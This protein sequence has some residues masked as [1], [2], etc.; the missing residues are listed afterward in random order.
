[1]EFEVL[2]DLV[3]II[4]RN[5]VK[6]IEVLGNPGQDNSR[7]EELY[8]GIGK[9]RFTSDDEAAKF[10]FGTNEK[11]PNYRK[12]R[13]KLIR[14]LI[15]T[16]FFID[17]QQPMFSERSKAQYHCYRDYAA[18]FILRTREAHKASVYLLQQVLEQAIKYEFTELTADICQQLR[19]QFARTP[20][21]Q[22]SHEKYSTLHRLYEEKRY[23]EVK[24]LDYHEN[25]IH[26]YITGRSASPEVHQLANQYFEELMPMAARI[27]T[28]QFYLYTY[29]VGVIKYLSVNNCATTIEI[30]DE[31]LSL[32]QN[33]KSSYSG[34]LI[35]FAIQKLACL[36]Q[37]RLNEKDDET[38]KYCL[39]LV[40]EGGFNWFRVMELLF[41]NR[42]YNHRYPDALEIFTKA[43]QHPRFQL[44]SGSFRDLWTLCGGYLHLLAALGKL[45]GKEVEEAAGFFRMAKFK[46]DF[47]VLDKEKAGMNIPLVLLPVM[48]SIATGAY[49]EEF[50]RSI[51]ALDK[52]RKRYLENDTNR[53]S[54]IFLKMLLALAKKNFE[55]DQ[56]LRKMEKEWIQL[57]QL[58]PQMGG[59]SFAVEIIPYEDL[60]GMLSG[61]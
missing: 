42:I 59:Q 5:K 14:Q 26:H 7:T 9:E 10:F 36:T 58:P 15:N 19:T 25:L 22:A 34:A 12:L 47:E 31:A 29:S 33:R 4:T 27:D 13:N 18:A 51:E 8:E 32:I 20:G 28:I 60:W 56:A 53:R 48:Y 23:W 61:R 49:E 3:R 52:Y 16:S 46:N 2:K 38:G 55:G 57:Q 30:C 21:D 43:V 45:N 11:D 6:Q 1:M 40:E 41:Y 24:A 54:A 50:G 39:N 37:L 17:V 35:S 44:L